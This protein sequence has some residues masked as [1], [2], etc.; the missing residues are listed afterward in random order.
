[1][2]LVKFLRGSYANYKALTPDADSIYITTDEGGIYLGSKRLGDYVMVNTT[3]DL[4][5]NAHETALY[6]VRNINVLCRWD[7]SSSK[8]VQINAAGLVDIVTE[9]TGNVVSGVSVVDGGAGQPRK[10]KITYTNVATTTDINTLKGR[11]DTA[12]GN[13]TTLKGDAN[14]A[15]SVAHSVK[16]LE[17]ALKPLI[18]TAQDTADGAVTV[19]N[20][21]NGKISSLETK[22]S[23]AEGNITTLQGN[24][25]TLNGDASTTG[26]VAQKIKAESD[27]LKGL[28][29]EAKGIAEG[30]VT[31]NNTQNGKI[32]ALEGKMTTAEG[33]ITTLQGDL[34]ALKGNGEGSVADQIKDESDALKVLIQAAQNTADGA[35]S[36]NNTQNGK[37]TA[38]EGKMTT[39]EG[40]IT[41]LNGDI[42][43]AGSVKKTVNDAI[44]EI[45]ANDSDAM[46]SI[47]DIVNWVTEHS[48]DAAAM[49]RQVQTNKSDITGLKGRMDTA[50]GKIT[51]LE[52]ALEDLVGDG[53][54]S[55]GDQ[56]AEESAR[57]EGLIT[58]AKG[59]AEGAVTVNN[60]QNGKISSLEGKVST[61][62]GNIT[63]L[64][65]AVN[66][67]NGD[68]S[69]SGSVAQKIKSE[70]DSLKQL[71]QAAQNTA[72]GAVSVNTT[73]T[74]DISGLKTR[75]STAEGKI[76][77]LEGG[78]AD[79]IT[80][81]G[82][83]D[84]A[85]QTAIDNLTTA[86]NNKN[87]TQ[88]N[89]IAAV[90]TNADNAIA[91]LTWG[92][93]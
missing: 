25:Q 20:T 34:A 76:T 52:G 7:S 15:G 33:N 80:A 12:E 38:L 82:N 16:A 48:E 54:G 24:V 35:V 22:M 11:M 74:N 27:T 69:T 10:L 49:D 18:Q 2:A 56:I 19:N 8:W 32:T 77:T 53:E 50:E 89:A 5:A 6:Y 55:I 41:T 26:S 3:D 61:A 40:A 23:T 14:T 88:D 64:Q 46:D 36:V 47:T 62:E 13:I 44:A 91:A 71:I 65:T 92:S 90:K 78:L 43:T 87:T 1:M 17:D 30:A 21:Q 59:I 93:F 39:V 67:L 83:G 31:V 73:Q 58:E 63:N 57:L 4:P 66:T 42:N 72:D 68:A 9:G 81:R 28:I 75:M 29:N 79:E 84:A 70:S 51:T 60:T 37:I 45:I 85:L 86:V